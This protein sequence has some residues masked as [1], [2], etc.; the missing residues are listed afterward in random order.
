MKIPFHISDSASPTNLPVWADNVSSLLT[1]H[2]RNLALALILACSRTHSVLV[3]LREREAWHLFKTL[4]MPN[5]IMST[6]NSYYCNQGDLL[7]QL[8]A[9]LSCS[10]SLMVLHIDFAGPFMSKLFLVIVD[11]HSKWFGVQVMKSITP[12]KTIKKLKI[13]FATHG[14]PKRIVSDSG[15]TFTSK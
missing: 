2:H 8:L 13:L 9:L 4:S 11:A 3:G 1:C 12:T 6:C 10:S 15:P 7:E 5:Y 14:I